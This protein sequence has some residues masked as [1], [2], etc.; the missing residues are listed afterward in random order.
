MVGFIFTG[1]LGTVLHFLFDWTNGNIFAALFSAVN[2]S[3]WEHMKLL[4]YPMV[5]F[6]VL[7]YRAWSR[8]VA[9]FWCVKLFG[10]LAGIVLI[11][12]LYYTYTGILGASAGWF[13]IALFFIVAAFVYWLES[14][15]FLKGVTYRIPDRAAVFG[16]CL[17]GLAFTVL[18]FWPPHV[19][20]FQDPVSGT[21]GYFKTG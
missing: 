9:S 2:E 16:I 4:F 11:P 14:K 17:V 6:A 13:N 19:P 1:V 3:I 8:E 21:Y 12:V 5:L 15:M 7:Q 18:T 10:I 20:L